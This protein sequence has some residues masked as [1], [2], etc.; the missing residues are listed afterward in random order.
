MSFGLYGETHSKEIF[1]FRDEW[2]NVVQTR[3]IRIHPD[4]AVI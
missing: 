3:F 4:F 1:N 2:C